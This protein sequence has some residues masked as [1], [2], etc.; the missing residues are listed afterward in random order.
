MMR[1]TEDMPGTAER[2][3]RRSPGLIAVAKTAIVALGITLVPQG[4]WSALIVTNLRIVPSVPWAVLLMAVLM[5]TGAQYLRGAWGPRST[6]ASRRQS[7]RATVV[8]RETFAW[9]SLGGALSMIAL[10]GVWI[11]LASFI[12]M[13]GSVLPD[14]SAYPRWTVMLSI[15]MGALISPLCEQAGVWGYG[16]GALERWSSGVTAVL[17]ASLVFALLPHP[18]GNVPLV[19]KVAFFFLAGL[20]FSTMTCLTDSIVPAI[21]VH[22]IGLLVFFVLVWP[23]DPDRRLVLAAGTDGWFWIHVG[24]VVVC[25]ALGWWAFARLAAVNALTGRVIANDISASR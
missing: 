14:L 10:V 23:L 12:R 20:I 22:V 11:L 13:P 18:P 4:V 8:S 15:G 1:W 5:V 6:A 25:A 17:V 9:A 2:V 21:P 19:A 3:E 16:Q 24:Q 7:L